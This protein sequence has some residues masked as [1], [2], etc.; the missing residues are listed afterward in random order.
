MKQ[1]TWN[2]ILKFELILSILL[3]ILLN[4]NVKGL[5]WSRLAVADWISLAI[6][7]ATLV[8]QFLAE[9]NHCL[10]FTANLLSALTL[11]CIFNWL[12]RGTISTLNEKNSAIGSYV[13]NPGLLNSIS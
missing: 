8:L 12:L 11:L 6:L 9:K 7:I 1:K 2:Q 13:L 10:K 3:A 5:N 4:I